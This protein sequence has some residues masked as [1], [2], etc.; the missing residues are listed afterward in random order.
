MFRYDRKHYSNNAEGLFWPTFWY[1]VVSSRPLGFWLGLW[2]I[3]LPGGSG[4][5]T[6]GNVIDRYLFLSLTLVGV[7]LLNRRGFEWRTVFR[8][9]PQLMMLLA[10][11]AL[12]ILWSGFPFVSFK[13]YIKV[14]GSIVMAF[15]V[16]DQEDP[17]GAFTTLLRRCLY[18]HI[19]MS[20]ICTRYFRDIGVSFEWNGTTEEWQG[21]ATSK[22]TL[23]QVTMLAVVYFSWQVF[24]NWRT[25][26]L[27]NPH[28][29]YVLL[30]LYL[31]KGAKSVSMTSASVCVLALFIFV[32]LHALRWNW[33][34]LQGF[35]WKMFYAIAALIIFVVIHS[36][37]H[38]TPESFFGHVITTLGRDITLTDRTLIWSDVYAAASQSPV[39]GVG[40]GGFWIGRIANIPW[41]AH[42]TWVLGQAHS[43]YVDTYLQLG[44]VGVFL[45]ARVLVSEVPKLLNSMEEDFEFGCFRITL[46][47]TILYVNMTESIYLRGDHHLWL[48]LMIVLW[49]V[50][51]LNR[52]ESEP[53]AISEADELPD[54]SAEAASVCS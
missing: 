38:F 34:R 32:R 11:M 9:N 10:Y 17:L 41:N 24:R 23:G 52:P 13:R 16:L 33:G 36:V 53:G 25:R 43:G 12:S 48:I 47:L 3:P 1:M 2:G 15:V 20:V 5:P 40:F 19:P 8:Q 35:V 49:Q 42:M 30:S 22:N 44:F 31:L 21:I 39:F 50:P 28:I 27:R 51:R 4:D 7:R 29:L 6:E 18:I 45:L 26:G 37:V 54:S 46:F 14:V